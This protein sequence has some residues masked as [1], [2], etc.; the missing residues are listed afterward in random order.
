MRLTTWGRTRTAQVDA[1]TPADASA[2]AAVVR[3]GNHATMVAYG[4][5]RCYGDSSLNNGGDAL[6]TS[7][8]AR[9]GAFD[10]RTLVA[11]FES[12][13]TFTQLAQA[14]HPRGLSFAVSSATGAVTIGGAIAN[15]IHSKNHHVAGSFGRN[16]EWID[17]ML[18]S[19]DVCR[20]SRTVDEPLFRATL[21]GM[22]LTGVVLAAGVRLVAIPSR[23]AAVRYERIADV[24]AFLAR[25][26][27]AIDT[28]TPNF[29][30]G[31]F[32]ALARGA[33]LGRG[34]L[35]TGR[36]AAADSAMAPLPKPFHFRAD[37]PGVAMHPA[38]IARYNA[39]R[40]AKLPP[41]GVHATVALEKFFF[42]LDHLVGFNR[43]YGRRGFYSIHAGIPQGDHRAVRRLLEAVSHARAG[44]IAAVFKPMSGPGEGLM[45]FPLRGYA[46][47]IDM[48]RRSGVEALHAQL[49]R[50]VL[51]AGGRLYVAKDALMSA[52]GFAQ[53][54]PRLDA[55]RE[56]LARV[57]PGRRFQS[58]MSRRLGI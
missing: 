24:D 19:G 42:P 34:I 44:A 20:V 8:L 7:G 57:D 53:M 30:F 18:A 10:P 26:D 48:P 37:L 54:F 50:I 3:D 15:D 36:Y 40:L 39:R 43:V 13:V 33:S 12:G 17:L 55:F 49:E 16:V 9:I 1:S 21:G 2:V 6:L 5:G 4:G 14:F 29:W 52:R 46:C 35:E 25:L 41:S 47:A 27:Q 31:W 23:A 51:D 58:D 45:S 11:T 22:G 28:Q 32:D 38:I 56:V